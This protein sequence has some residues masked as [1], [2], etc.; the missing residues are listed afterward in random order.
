MA[1]KIKYGIFPNPQPDAEG[2][3]TY[4][5]RHTPE[6]TM[7]EKAFLAHLKYYNTYNTT[8]ML[9]SLIVLK[10]EIIE[11]LR[12][13]K[14]FRIDGLGTFQMKVGLKTKYD[15]EGNPLKPHYTDPDKIT[16]N[17]VEVQGVSFTPDPSF[18]KALKDRT[19]TSNKYGRGAAGKNQ[20]YTRDEIINFLDNY[21]KEH[22]SMTRRQM[23][24]ELNMTA[25]RAQKWLDDITA[26]SF[27]KYYSKKQGNTYV[28]YRYGWE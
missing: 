20:P 8:A 19:S 10:D 3:T 5:V 13:N 16:A 1:Y 17:D 6:G 25:Y 22:H 24:R 11:Q 4:Q 14:R 9:S 21:L 2:N 12:E 7:N 28:Y 18:V 26:E 15:E 27:S 23:E